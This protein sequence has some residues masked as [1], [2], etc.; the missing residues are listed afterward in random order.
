[1]KTR[2]LIDA[3][4]E[5]TV[6]ICSLAHTWSIGIALVVAGYGVCRLLGL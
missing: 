3:L 1:M 5:V 4:A 6:S 2:T